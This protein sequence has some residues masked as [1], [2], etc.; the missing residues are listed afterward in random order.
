MRTCVGLLFAFLAAVSV[1]VLGQL[2][3]RVVNGDWNWTP[4]GWLV[5][6]PLVIA[7]FEIIIGLPIILLFE[8]FRRVSGWLYLI[9]GMVVGMIPVILL[10]WSSTD[11]YLSDN[12]PIYT[13]DGTTPLT[14][15]ETRAMYIS[16]IQTT[17]TDLHFG[18]YAGLIGGVGG[19]AFRLTTRNRQS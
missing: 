6:M 19:L 13:H 10:A 14:F 3:Q 4:E 12:W 9:S 11:V 15:D 16:A 1:W 5:L 7:S 2:A 8:T 17:V 18:P